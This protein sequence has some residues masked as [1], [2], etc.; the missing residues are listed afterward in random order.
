MWNLSQN[1]QELV[2]RY[3]QF[4]DHT[5]FGADYE[6]VGGIAH[7]EM[8]GRT[9]LLALVAGGATPRFPD[10]N[11]MSNV[12]SLLTLRVVFVVIGH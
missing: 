7:A 12:S 6:T 9:N 8:L 4:H 3:F 10:R 5:A 1:M 2:R 11:G